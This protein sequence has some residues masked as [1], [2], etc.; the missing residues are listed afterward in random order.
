MTFFQGL[1]HAFGP[2]MAIHPTFFF[3]AIQAR[4]MCFTIFQNHETHFQAIKTKVRKVK[5]LT[6]FHAFGP[7]MTIFATFFCAIQAEKMSFTI[8]QNQKTSFQA[9]KTQSSKSR[10]IDIFPKGI[11]HAFGPK[12]AIY[13]IFFFQAIQARKKSFTIF[14]NQKTPFQAIKTQSLKGQ[15]I[16]IFPK[17]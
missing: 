11:T 16:D 12:M 3:Q 13:P 5:K 9:R 10:K 15:K 4:K 2:K 8:F 1:T 7:K 17:G 6:F 14:Q